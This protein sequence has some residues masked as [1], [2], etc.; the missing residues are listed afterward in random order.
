MENLSAWQKKIS[1][2]QK[3]TIMSL[4]ERFNRP[5]PRYTSYPTAKQF[6]AIEQGDE[7]IDEPE[8]YSQVDRKVNCL[9]LYFHIPFCQQLCYYCGCHKFITQN[10]DK[11]ET[12]LNY[13]IQEVELRAKNCP[14]HV[15]VTD[16]HLGGGT[17]T[18]L[19]DAQLERL[20]DAIKANFSIADGCEWA[21]E[22]DPRTVD[23]AR[24]KNII[25]IGF[26]RFSL[27]I[28]D[29][30][31]KTQ[32]A[33]NRQQSYQSIE[34]IVLAI[35]QCQT[36]ETDFSV[37]FDLIYGLPLQNQ[38]SFMQTLENVVS[39]NPDRIAMF[40]YA[41]M[42]KMFPAQAKIK[43]ADLPNAQL[44][45]AILIDAINYLEQNGY[46]QVG[47]DH[48]VKV[49]DNLYQA[50]QNETLTRNFQGYADCETQ[51]MLGFGVSAISDFSTAMLQN[52]KQLKAYYQSIDKQ[53]MPFKKVIFRT[54]QDKQREG[55]IHHLLCHLEIPVNKLDYL[56]FTSEWLAL[57]QL[58]T[59][60]LLTIN[61]QQIKVT[62]VGQIFIRNI[63]Q[64]FDSYNKLSH[65]TG[66]SNAI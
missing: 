58:E 49:E 46:R 65:V 30:N 42:P 39:L 53:Q 24:I 21:I 51:V 37:N 14:E 6:V 52:E 54:Q 3:Q 34:S 36:L 23:S 11:A 22:I 57:K 45:V 60:G 48:F 63:A 13:L 17:P 15:K 31:D 12:Y 33:I 56:T 41:H 59:L 10:K 38:Q 62:M 61:K 40:N 16:I 8:L 9:S 2:Q 4:V 28:Q 47:L 5:C 19:T 35:R 20:F 50:L 7:I 29:F 64:I 26:N 43:Q 32:I 55:L 25:N 44:K 66:F 27:G 1:A 18:F